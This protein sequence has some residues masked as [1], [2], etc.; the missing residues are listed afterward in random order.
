MKKRRNSVPKI[1]FKMF[2]QIDRIERERRAAEMARPM[3]NVFD[4]LDKGECY[5]VNGKAVM[6]LTEIDHR[7]AR[8][9][10]WVSVTA[11]L[12]SWIDCWKRLAP[13]ISTYNM[14]VLSKKLAEWATVTPRLVEMARAEFDATIDRLVDI[15]LDQVSSAITTTQIA[16]ELQKMSKVA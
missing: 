8:Q 7:Y 14:G 11:T 6:L 3:R 4:L 12:D 9:G 15:P 5:E 16:L 13:D 10:R 1:Y 2:H